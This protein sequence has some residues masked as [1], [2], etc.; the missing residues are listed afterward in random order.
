MSREI[1]L[2]GRSNVGKSTLFFQITG[3]KVRTGK[4]PGITQYPFKA[5]VGDIFYV[6]MPGYG[7]MLKATKAEQERTRDL[8]VKY[9]EEHA[10]EILLAVQVIDTSS[11]LDIA[12]RWEGR[13]EV[14]V[15]IELWEFLGDVGLDAVL[16]ANKIDR[17]AKADVDGALDLI[18]ERL[19]MLPPWTQWLDRVAPI[20]AKR[21]QIKPLR[22]II[23]RRLGGGAFN[24]M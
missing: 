18:C 3:K 16:A 2:V 9:F 12:D 7:F 23:S 14:P 6:D 8:I 1:V 11:F 5:K 21:G 19:G 4:R 10:R 13:G 17:I 24:E 20:S 15:E 22:E